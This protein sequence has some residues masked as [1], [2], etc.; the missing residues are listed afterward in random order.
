MSYM[1]L[2]KVTPVILKLYMS[3]YMLIFVI[4]VLNFALE[5]VSKKD[6]QI[7]VYSSRWK[8]KKGYR[9]GKEKRWNRVP[10]QELEDMR[11]LK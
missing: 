1:T 3:S 6:I 8:G 5:L 2:W 9:K 7:A 10:F 4:K 11:M